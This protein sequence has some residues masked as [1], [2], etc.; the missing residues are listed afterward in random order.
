[1][2]STSSKS[3]NN[4]CTDEN[5]NLFNKLA[6]NTINT[7][8]DDIFIK[9]Y[10]SECP[11][12]L[13]NKKNIPR[14]L[15]NKKKYRGIVI[16]GFGCKS[17]PQHLEKIENHLTKE[18]K[19]NKIYLNSMTSIP[20]DV[21][22]DESEIVSVGSTIVATYCRIAPWKNDNFVKS[23]YEKVENYINDGFNIILIGHSYGG[24]V[25]ARVAEMFHDIENSNSDIKNPNIEIFTMG[26]IYIPQKEKVSKIKIKHY[27]YKFDVALKCNGISH[28]DK[29][30]TWMESNLKKPKFTF[31][32]TYEQWETHNKYQNEILE[33]LLPKN[34]NITGGKNN[35]YKKMPCKQSI[36]TPNKKMPC[37]QSIKTPKKKIETNTKILSKDNRVKKKI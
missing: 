21:M 32:G 4:L 2:G 13:D 37:K 12:S 31:L 30:I 28:D 5:E 6:I 35:R 27:M 19:R 10:S 9:K 22:C 18:L 16:Y 17:D 24:S 8:E 15:D 33:S 14:S 36:K 3:T 29:R 23:V 7:L 25:V 20:I 11:R 26:S 34:N 1:M